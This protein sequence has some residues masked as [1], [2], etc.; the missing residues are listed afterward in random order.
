MT[1]C[2][3]KENFNIENILL[4]KSQ[5][6]E[7][8][9]EKIIIKPILYKYDHNLIRRF[10]F[11]TDW[12]HVSKYTNCTEYIGF[13]I[14]NDNMINIVQQ[15]RNKIK[16]NTTNNYPQLPDSSD[17]D[18]EDE[19]YYEINNDGVNINQQNNQ[20]I[21]LI[22][23]ND[24]T[25]NINNIEHND[26]IFFRFKNTSSVT[27]HPSKK[28]NLPEYELTKIE[29]YKEIDR[30]Y[31]AFN[32]QGEYKIVGKFLISVNCSLYK[33]DANVYKQDAIVHN[34][35]VYSIKSGELKYEKSFIKDNKLKSKSV[36]DD[37]I[38]IDI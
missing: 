36:F 2:I 6:I 20:E 18:E 34:N 22:T 4:G 27:L 32:K 31:P 38:K 37:K 30:Y 33:Q 35:I 14:N 15:I 23:L 26:F 29:N 24:N 9:N 1:L 11:L 8:E 3:K 25:E 17:D 13:I 7:K 21:D 5:V 16:F 12:I 19:E 10:Y 28:S